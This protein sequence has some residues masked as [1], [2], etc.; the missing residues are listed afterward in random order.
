MESMPLGKAGVGSAVNDTTREVG[1]S[2]G[3]AV[4][5]SLL[6]TRYGHHLGPSLKGVP[7]PVADA[8]R[9]SLG[10]ALGVAQGH[11]GLGLAA[12]RAFVDGMSAVFLAAAGLAVATA[13]AVGIGLPGRKEPSSDAHP[14]VSVADD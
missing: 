5:G 11:P 4:L 2:L 13:V 12:R 3:V 6:A 14:P 9:R 7:R 1:G 8:A 10:S